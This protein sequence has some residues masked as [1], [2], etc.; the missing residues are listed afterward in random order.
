[1][2][3][4]ALILALSEPTSTADPFA[5]Q[6]PP[7]EP[8]CWRMGPVECPLRVSATDCQDASGL[9]GPCDEW[10]WPDSGPPPWVEPEKPAAP[11]KPPPSFQGSFT[12]P[13][14]ANRSTYSASEERM[15]QEVREQY[16]LSRRLIVAGAITTAIGGAATVLGIILLPLAAGREGGISNSCPNPPT[17]TVGK[18]CGCACISVSDTCNVGSGITVEAGRSASRPMRIAGGV[19]LGVGIAGIIAGI[20]CLWQGHALKP[21]RYSITARGFSVHF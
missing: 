2:R 13:R 6:P 9:R 17:C 20:A 3:W 8:E 7:K 11:P 4:I 16:A 10:L 5:P 18:R 21:S 1:M 15:R 19:S 12:S 14:K